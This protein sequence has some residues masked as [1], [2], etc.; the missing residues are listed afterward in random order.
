MAGEMNFLTGIRTTRVEVIRRCRYAR[1]R[2][3][4]AVELPVNVVM[5]HGP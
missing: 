3:I 1:K 2:P 5:I 4:H